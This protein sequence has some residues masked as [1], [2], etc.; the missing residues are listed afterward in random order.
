MNPIRVI[1]RAVSFK[2]MGIVIWGTVEG[3]IF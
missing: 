2:C 1:N 3:V